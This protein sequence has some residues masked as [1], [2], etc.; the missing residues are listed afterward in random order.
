M[1]GNKRSNIKLQ[2]RE[3]TITVEKHLK[4]LWI[5]EWEYQFPLSERNVGSFCENNNEY[6]LWDM[7]VGAVGAAPTT[8]SLST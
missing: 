4:K 3:P 8:S 1:L 7:D 6:W 5:Q 2:Y